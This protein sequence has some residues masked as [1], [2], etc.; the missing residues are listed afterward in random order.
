MRPTTASGLIGRSSGTAAAVLAVAMVTPAPELTEMTE[1][2][3]A[4]CLV[5]CLFL[6]LSVCLIEL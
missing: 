6:C 1:L 5:G 4:S 3:T 2:R